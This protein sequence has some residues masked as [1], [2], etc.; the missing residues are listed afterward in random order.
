MTKHL[1]LANQRWVDRGTLHH[2]PLRRKIANGETNRR[3]SPRARA[4]S[5]DMITSSGSIPSRSRKTAAVPCVLGSASTSPG[6]CP[7]FLRRRSSPWYRSVWPRADGASLQ[8]R[9][10]PG[11]PAPW[12]VARPVGERVHQPR[13]QAV[14][15]DPIPSHRRLQARC[16]GNGRQV[17]QQVRRSAEGRMHHHGVINGRGRKH[18]ADSEAKLV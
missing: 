7:A 13:H 17:N 3:R 1:V 14:H 11:I 12:Q 2:R 8:A 9:R 6:R 16:V 4:P 15:L 5:G 18:I 10:Q